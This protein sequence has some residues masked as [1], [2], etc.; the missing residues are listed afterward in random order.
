MIESV[1]SLKNLMALTMKR[2]RLLPFSANPSY[3]P[4]YQPFE[5]QSAFTFTSS[6]FP[7]LPSSFANNFSPSPY[8]SLVLSTTPDEVPQNPNMYIPASFPSSRKSKKEFNAELQKEIQRIK[9]DYDSDH[10]LHLI[11][12][13]PHMYDE[14]DS[15]TLE[16][17]ASM[18]DEDDPEEQTLEEE[19][20]ECC[21]YSSVSSSSSSDDKDLNFKIPSWKTKKPVRI[22][23][24]FHSSLNE[25]PIR[26]FR[27]DTIY[28]WSVNFKTT[29]EIKEMCSEM[30]T[31]YRCYMASSMES[32]LAY[33]MI[34]SGFVGTLLHW[35]WA[36]EQKTPGTIATWKAMILLKTGG[37]DSGQPV[38]DRQGR[39]VSNTL[40]CMIHYLQATFIGNEKPKE[41]VLDLWLQKLKCTDLTQFEQH[42][43]LFV[44]IAFQ[45]PDPL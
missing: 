19:N 40:D 34:V 43:N 1:L 8:S 5:K 38:L 18:K 35:Y 31:A 30:L 11:E 36:V 37:N 28:Y 27:V 17:L 13:D 44:K 4:S 33:D 26:E 15:T 25:K 24:E 39:Q 12:Y 45:L 3:H 14:F 23:P 9:D 20:I 2:R 22:P 32:N 10:S 6:P 41:Q 16:I 29:E 21:N 42:F 7:L